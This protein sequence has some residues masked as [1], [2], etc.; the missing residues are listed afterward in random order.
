MKKLI[1]VTV[2]AECEIDDACYDKENITDEEIIKI[3]SGFW[4]EWIL[5]NIK[6]EKV[7]VKDVKSEIVDT[8]SGK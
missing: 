4:P 6:S 5:D 2:V 1:R 8:D 7:E 3:E